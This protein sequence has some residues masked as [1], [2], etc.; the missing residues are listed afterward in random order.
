MA[1]DSQQEPALPIGDDSTRKSE[2]LL[3][4]YFRTDANKKILSSTLDQLV[5]SGVAEKINGYYGR[6]TAK[7]FRSNDD[8]IADVSKQR[9][10]RQLEPAATVLDDLGNVQFYADYSD[11][12]NQAKNFNGNVE[13][14]S[15]FNSQ[16]YYSWNPNVDWDK[17]TNF[18]EYYW[19][20]N[21]PQTVTVFGKNTDEQ[22][23][24]TVTTEDNDDNTVYKFDP[25]GFE[26]NPTLTLYRGQTYK[27]KIDSVGHPFSITTNRKFDDTEF[28]VIYDEDSET[29]NLI[30]PKSGEIQAIKN[31]A[32]PSVNRSVGTYVVS[33]YQ[34]TGKG[35]FATFEVTVRVGGS[36]S[37]AVLEGGEDFVPG[38]VITIFDEDLGEGGAVNVRFEVTKIFNINLDKSN[39]YVEGLKAFDETG[40]PVAPIGLEKG[41]IEFTVPYNAPENLYY[42][43]STD[44]N[45]SGYIKI[46]NI[47]DRTEINVNDI[48][49][50][51]TYT[52]ANGVEFTNGLKV[53]FAGK[54]TPEKYSTGEWYVEGVGTKIELVNSIDLTITGAFTE[55]RLVPFDSDPFDRLP[56]GDD[57][58]Y[59]RDK[60]YHVI[61]R[62]SVDR[63]AWSRYNRWFHIDVIA[64][65]AEYNGQQFVVD[66][67]ARATRPIV[68]F[69]TGLKLFN[70]GTQSKQSIDVIDTIT[71]DAFSIVEGSTG[72]NV[73]EVQLSQGMRIIFLADPDTLVYGKIFEVNFITI[74]NN[75]QISLIE[76]SDTMPLENEN[77]LVKS[78]QK[79]GGK[80]YYFDGTHWNLAQEKLSANQA[81]LFDLFDEDGYSL[82]DT[83]YYP[84]SSFAGNKVFGYV[85][86]TLE[87]ND[88]E[89]GFP[90]S[91]KSIENIGDILFEFPLVN[92]V[93]QYQVD[94]LLQFTTTDKAYLRTYKSLSEYELH[95]G[96]TKAE[97]NSEQAVV[98][99]YVLDQDE[100]ELELDAFDNILNLYKDGDLSISTFVN[101]V[102]T[103]EFRYIE[104]VDKLKIVVA[105]SKANDSVVIKQFSSATANDNGYYDMA[106]NLERNPLNDNPSIFT[107]GE[108]NDHV[109]SIVEEVTSNN[110]YNVNKAAKKYNG[111]FP[112]RS[113]LRDLGNVD[114]FGKRFIKH[115]GPV[116][117]AMYH[118]TDKDAN[119]VKAIR[120]SKI[121]YAKFK[122]EFLQV[123][124]SLGYDGPVK[125]HVDKIL[126][127]INSEKTEGMPFYFSD[128]VPISGAKLTQFEVKPSTQNFF[129]LNRVFNLNELSP[130]AVLVYRNGDQLLHNKD[131]VFTD[132]GF[133]DISA[134]LIVGDIIDVY[135]YDSTDGSFIPS[136]PTKLGLYPAFE[137]QIYRDTTSQVPRNVIQG[138]DGSLILAYGDYRD[139]LLLDL[140]KRIFNNIKQK[141]NKEVFDIHEFVGGTFRDTRFT[142]EQI[143][144]S[145]TTDF[146][147]WYNIAGTPNYTANT[148]YRQA[149]PFTYNFKQMISPNGKSLPGFWRGVYKE[150]FD[151][152]RPHTHPW[153]M[154][155]FT[156]KPKWWEEQY[157]AAPY[158]ASNLVMWEDL[159][160]GLIKEPG[161]AVY[162]DKKYARPGLRNWLPVDDQGKLIDPLTS[163]YA[164][165]YVASDTREPYAF[166]D[167][168]PAESAW[169]QSAEYPFA[170][171]IS[172]VVSQPS[173]VVGTGFDLSR[174]VRNKVGNLVYKETGNAIR[175]TDLRFPNTTQADQRVLTSG[176]VNFV[177]N[178]L[179][180]NVNVT[181]E[182]YINKLTNLSNNLAI[183]IG[184]YTEKEKFNLILDSRTPLNQG[185]VF[186]PKE[187][188]KII[189]N[190]SSPIDFAS[191]SGVI[192]EKA[193]NGFIV[194][195]YDQELSIFKHFEPISTQFDPVINVGGISEEF[196]NWKER[197]QYIKGQNVRFNTKYYRVVESHVSTVDFD[198]TKFKEIA[199]LPQV[200]GR[201]GILRRQFTDRLIETPYGTLLRT[202][203]DVVDFLLGYEEYLKQQGFI[204]DYFNKETSV[205]EDWTY[206]VK[207][208]LFWTTQ[209]WAAGTVLALSP[210][211][212]QIKFRRDFVVVDDIFDKFYNYSLIKA[213]GKRIQRNFSSIARDDENF[214][215]LRVKNTADGIYGVKLPLVQREHVVLLDNETV[216]GDV[217]YDQTAGYR[218]ERIKVTGYRSDNWKG[219]LNAPGFIY[220]EA[221]VV[222]WEPWADYSIGTLVKYKEFYY[223][224][225]QTIAGS[226]VFIANK[227]QRL[228]EKPE[229]RLT[230]NFDYK[231]N[232]FGDFYDLDSDNFDVEQQ[233]HAQH[234]IGYQ[235]RQYLQNIINDD[236]S[237]YKFYQGMIQDKGTTNALTKLFDALSSANKDSLEFYEE[238][239]LR[240]GQYGAVDSYDEVEFLLDESKFRIDPQ[241]IEN[242][243]ELPIDD[244]DLTYKIREFEIFSKPKVYN[245]LSVFPTVQ[246]ENRDIRSSG[247]VN[248]KDVVYR[249]DNLTD[250]LNADVN[251]IGPNDYIWVTGRTEDWDVLQHITTDYKVVSIQGFEASADAIDD[252][253]TPLAT[254]VLTS[255]TDFKV[256]DV[257]GIRNLGPGNDGFYQIDGIRNN[258]LDLVAG[259]RQNITDVDDGDGYISILRSVR[260]QNIQTANS[261]IEKNLHNNQLLWI[262][263]QTSADWNVIEKKESFVTYKEY[264]NDYNIWESSGVEQTDIVDSYASSIAVSEEN[265]VIA[266]ANPTSENGKVHIYSRPNYITEFILQDILKPDLGES[267][268]L[269]EQMFGESIDISPDGRLLV[270]G[271]PHSSD[272]ADFYNNTTYSTLSQYSANQIVKYEENYWRA[273]RT[274][275]PETSSVQFSTFDAY[276]FI[277][278]S[279]DNEGLLT[280][281]REEDDPNLTLTDIGDIT[282]ILQG[283]P[284]F[285]NTET[286]HLLIRAPY[287]QYRATKPNDK[288][289]LKWNEYTNLNRGATLGNSIQLFTN[290]INTAN[291]G[292]NYTIPD[293]DF[294]T[295]EHLIVA[296]VDYVL[297]FTQFQNPP[298]DGDVVETDTGAATVYKQTI[299]QDKMVLYLTG[300]NGEILSSDTLRSNRTGEEIGQFTQPNYTKQV[301]LGG[302]WYINS[303]TY[304]TSNEFTE[305][306]NF[307]IPGFGLV[308]QDVLV[309]DEDTDSYPNRP[310]SPT[311]DSIPNYYYNILDDV[312]TVG[313]TAQA[314]FLATLSHIGDAYTSPA[315]AKELST[316]M[317][318]LPKSIEDDVVVG[319]N[320]RVYVDSQSPSYDYDLIGI[321]Q[322]LEEINTQQHEVLDLWD[323][324]IDF[325]QEETQAGS[326]TDQ[327]GDTQDFFEPLVGS[328]IRD[329]F[330]RETAEVAY[331]IKRSVNQA[332]V[333][334]K[335]VS[336]TF[337]QGNKLIVD[338]IEL[339]PQ[340][341]P[342]TNRRVMGPIARTSLASAVTGKL[343]ILA[344]P[345][346]DSNPQ[347][348]NYLFPAH[349][350]SYGG[351]DEFFDLNVFCYTNQEYWIYKEKLDEEGADLPPSI[352]STVNADWQLVYNM[353][354]GVGA[355]TNG[356]T[357]QGTYSIYRYINSSWQFVNTYTLP[358]TN[359][360]SKAGQKVKI[361]QDGLLYTIF[362]GSKEKVYIIKHGEDSNGNRYEY[363]LDID[364]KYR[365]AYNPNVFYAIN[366]IVTYTYNI[367]IVQY[368]SLFQAKTFTNTVPTNT[369]KW[370]KLENRISYLPY[371][372]N[373]HA[374]Y[375]DSD[376]SDLI[377]DAD[378]LYNPL[379]PSDQILDFSQDIAVS[380][381]GDVLAISIK[382]TETEATYSSSTINPETGLPIYTSTMVVDTDN[383]V[384]IYR[385]QDSRYVFHQQIL[386]PR[387]QT[388]WG[389]SIDLSKDGNL[390][391][392]GE[393]GND[394]DSF[395]NGKVYVYAVDNATHFVE[396]QRIDGPSA[397]K[398]EKFGSKVSITHDYLGVS[399]FNGDVTL[400][401][402][403]DRYLNSL[404][405]SYELDTTS[406][407]REETTFDDGFTTFVT[408]KV[409]SGSVTLYQNF[410]NHFIKA[411]ELEYKE[412]LSVLANSRFGETLVVNENNIY[413]GIPNNP[414][415][416]ETEEYR[417]G[418][419]LDYSMVKGTK[420]WEVIRTRN[421]VVDTDKIK[422]AFLY[423]TTRNELITYL[424]FIDPVQGKIAGPADKELSFKS[425]IDLAR[426]NVTLYPSYFSETSNWENEHVG[427][428]WWDLSAVRFKDAYQEDPI[429][430]ANSW[431]N[432]IP[433]YSVDVYEWVESDV[434]PSEWDTQSENGTGRNNGISGTSKY[435]DEAYSQ[436]LV[437]DPISSSF[438]TK[439]YFWVKD[440]DIIP[441]VGDR[442]MSALNVS[443]MIA[444]PRGQGYQF[445]ALLSDNRFVLY[446]CDNLIKG[447]TVA[448]NIGYY[449]RDGAADQNIHAEYQILSEGLETSVP[450]LDI[451]RK[452]VDSLVGYDTKG[453]PVPDR[454]IP[455][456]QRYGNLNYPRQSW[457]V[458]RDEA[459]KQLV[460]RANIALQ[461]N[462][463]VDEFSFANLNKKEAQPL[464][465]QRL[466]DIKVD[467][468]DDLNFVGTI[469][470][471]SAQINVVQNNG[472]IT[473]T[474]IVKSGRGYVDP[475][476]DPLTSAKRFG[477]S[478]TVIGNGEGLELDFTINN[479]GQITSVDIINGGTNYD[480]STI[481]VVRPLSVLVESDSSVNGLWSIYHY[482]NE[483]WQ[484]VRVQS[485]NTE[486]Y[487]EYIDWYAT[488]YNQFT[489]IDYIVDYSYELSAL[490]TNIG[491]IVKI[492]SIGSGGWLLLRKVSDTGARDY[493]ID[494]ETIGRENG[495]IRI[496]PKLYDRG[497]SLVGFD[498]FPYDG[499]FYDSEPVQETRNILAALKEDIFV[500]N[501]ALKYN[502]LFFASIR[503][504]L[505]EQFNVDWVFKTSF[506]KAKHNVG[507]LEEK[508]TYQ[509]DNLE[510]YNDYINEVKPYKTNVREYLSS[511]E[512]IE[513]TQTLVTDFDVPAIYNPDTGKIQPAGIIVQNDELTRVDE[514][515]SEY[516][517][518]NWFDNVGFKVVG[519]HLYDQ[520]SGYTYPPTI[521]FVGGGGSG[522]EAKAYLGAGKIKSIEVTNPGKG[523]KSAP[524]VIVDGSISDNG[525][526]AIASAEIG[527][528]VTRSMK[529]GVKFDRLTGDYFIENLPQ[530]ETFTGTGTRTIYTLSWPM[531]MQ[532]NKVTV[533]VNDVKLLRNDYTYQN[534]PNTTYTYKRYFGEIKF[535]IP[536]EN[537]S[538]IRVEYHKDPAM[539]AAQDRINKFYAPTAGMPGI[540]LGQLME[541]VDYGGVQVKSFDFGGPAGWDT[542][543]WFSS[544]WDTYDNTFEDQ[545][546]VADG[547]TTVIEL[548]NPLETGVEYNVYR[549]G[550]RIDDPDYPDNPKNPNAIMTSIIGDGEQLL[551]DLTEFEITGLPGDRFIV[552]KSSS[553]GSFLPDPDSYDTILTGGDLNYGNAAGTKAE[554]IIVD[555]DL[556]VTSITSGGPEELVPGQVLDAVAITVFERVGAGSGDIIHQTMISDGTTTVYPMGILPGSDSSVIIK[557][558]GLLYRTT[559]YRLDYQAQTIIL[560]SPIAAGKRISILTVASSGEDILD[561]NTILTNGTDVIYK[562]NTMWRD[563]LQFFA[564]V[565]GRIAKGVELVIRESTD[566]FVEFEFNPDAP[567]EGT[568]LDYEIYS[569]KDEIN[570][571]RVTRD[572]IFADDTDTYTL[573]ESPGDKTPAEFFTLVSVDNRIYK[574]GYQSIFII[575]NITQTE[576]TLE[577][578]QVP[579]TSMTSDI[580]QVYL[581]NRRLLENE[582][583]TINSGNSSINIVANLTSLDDRLEV[584]VSNGEYR[585]FDDQLQFNK[586]IVL[587]SIIEVLQ[588]T[589]HSIPGLERMTYDVTRQQLTENDI[590]FV[591]YNNITAGKIVLNTPANSVNHVW[592]AKDKRLLTPSV[593]YVLDDDNQVIY[594][595]E[596][597]GTGGS[598]DVIQFGAQLSTPV[599][600]FKQFK[601]ILNRTQY[602]RF[603]NNEGITLIKPFLYND[604]RLE[605]TDASTLP[606]PSKK[607]NKP[608]I[609]FIGGERIEYFAKTGNSLRQLRRGTLGTGTKDV[610]EVGTPIVS[611]SSDKTI[612][613]KD[614]IITTNYTSVDNQKNFELDWVPTRGVDEFEV[615]AAGRRLRKNSIESFDATLGLD[616]PEGNVTLPAEF[617]VVNGSTLQLAQPLQEGQKLVVIRKLGKIWS[618]TGTPLKD[619]DNDIARFLRD[620]NS[621]LPK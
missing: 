454:D 92:D 174:T 352:P 481:I 143:N 497:D 585:I 94:N 307:G 361:A 530:T 412:D 132:E 79:N 204:F 209:N 500:D 265:T 590:E 533:F 472:V 237:Q 27:F 602:K 362:V 519:I 127:K 416:D 429:T 90:V 295:G 109:A 462:I 414:N 325:T 369:N 234:L 447:K 521:T 328:T 351:K 281:N 293:S 260:S 354:V 387:N 508:I 104:T 165:N 300:T 30:T 38:E 275:E 483:N 72:Y 349:P 504:V 356:K 326:D 493:T 40:K 371:I 520:G 114:I 594:L 103:E 230:P 276:P 41:E 284:Y 8:Y 332:R 534:V 448:L 190:T 320:I 613:Y 188:Y 599:I 238:W 280:A 384:L 137:P 130:R 278:I 33:N 368:T 26:S 125:T 616:S 256:R 449:L 297:Y 543:E 383:K 450:K 597:V 477:P 4:K 5:Q 577:T 170:L 236:V 366:D 583:Y 218:Q 470:I 546:F 178:Y 158:T 426:Y 117:L 210:G 348:G 407:T 139:Q 575:D 419:F 333:Y 154:L 301:A 405:E 469:K 31:K 378:P 527:D 620:S 82:S 611:G 124:E 20:P 395:N 591:R 140:E 442:S 345:A 13:N 379:I 244:T 111:I 471:E 552:R 488:G 1:N 128:M 346:T 556:F 562:T 183:K 113:N 373:D 560:N 370:I 219:G 473:K 621:R 455:Y 51:Q 433:N 229:P 607:Q 59:A 179:T 84:D 608:G 503:Y 55:N 359:S 48:I 406:E 121:E 398:S 291:V 175:V 253:D 595:Q 134:E 43:S 610:Y 498:Q 207:E 24:F 505:S 554:D 453:R 318:R 255:T 421:P 208:F 206:S 44:I 262:D 112:G 524:T 242:V 216:F 392:V 396:K 49:G 161:K 334:V 403:F 539:L 10:I 35:K 518:K 400:D 39:K 110:I 181:Y 292:V 388:D 17:L 189:L 402:R 522:A 517:D 298:A 512:K 308:Y 437:Y 303:P 78:G 336:G 617:A 93:V 548:K 565:N 425:H 141:Y 202:I 428:L 545:L 198:G 566:G 120:F 514:R 372:P 80:I 397:N 66:Q 212:Q 311:G 365:G 11:F 264:N 551:I 214:F 476:F 23:T 401:T 71:T 306:K 180:A 144:K 570:Y 196:I 131:Y 568:R 220:D 85:V 364:K 468:V 227:W 422:H 357:N 532:L 338:T 604:L 176:L 42:S 263:G 451:E 159:E 75:R 192:L 324:Y 101:G 146:I 588:F 380:R 173:K 553:D 314:G 506:I 507:E 460:E 456:K 563:D 122:R 197:K 99:Q 239:A 536:P 305:L 337:S 98:T 107:L 162:V 574:P 123:A 246:N 70:Y 118:I 355:P 317:V 56:F 579:T 168:S 45:T 245:H 247:Y 187:N 289:V 34:T 147:Q 322:V 270:V 581:N 593:D 529:V 330:T 573:T 515:F 376:S 511:Y 601:D 37:I 156:I 394:Q 374:I 87:D 272:V 223:V 167:H 492:A 76:T 16:E 410:D 254:V 494:W 310:L 353:P 443:R 221:R 164:S 283:T 513:N 592:V 350:E 169:R 598:V 393:P 251:R 58:A 274:V 589:N 64:K 133:I 172:W 528:S 475:T 115:S 614:E 385:L 129:A 547:S 222:D 14:Q 294:I 46:F 54:V 279:A 576:F 423:D 2:N 200:G 96:W 171:I 258:R 584:F 408:K 160:L 163:G 86:G 495:T 213:D 185:N 321:T 409:D 327:D 526:P 343:A 205:V 331:Y 464:P 341:N 363:A 100:E 404:P 582:E 184:G 312:Y 235:K 319:E 413:V 136:T 431:N 126:Q 249:I 564:R 77:V 580:V 603:D 487:W 273:V 465:T 444:D 510:S 347:P 108:I 600:A 377:D 439:Y 269:E 63:N 250:I 232:Q 28:R 193:A 73:D 418:S 313:L 89:L 375:T 199:D 386:A 81:P 65:S 459:L 572:R 135:E 195:G 97:F 540:D 335:N 482:V 241:P 95:T 225:T 411:E 83:T 153:E 145:L 496:L 47:I 88:P 438:S 191:F 463:I 561:I 606:V 152:D 102:I 203:Q 479:L 36:V 440:K 489:R 342:Q 467:T 474:R 389:S 32:G 91:Y 267:P 430:Q 21:G 501:L 316:W 257:I 612:P 523:Y 148:F 302:W 485:F 457:F 531:D 224:A 288:I 596:T 399:S 538:V 436:K 484:R 427:K 252:T 287:D 290:G 441:P 228:N 52:S 382:T 18:R 62:A 259:P 323:G 461:Q 381:K 304:I 516:P 116:N 424:D 537:N 142:R 296:K 509:N 286:S 15:L 226:E 177:Y 541:G 12:I 261:I 6:K 271:S 119:I 155:G 299:D 571:S 211:A 7:A 367:G 390:L 282:L 415:D 569:N 587:G 452:W 201:D 243:T 446:N 360:E 609:I 542:D 391:V 480:D 559:N 557:V 19:L 340:G 25:P 558:D 22:S 445:V 339:D 491:N 458:N 231:V 50:K 233:K 435:G 182:S 3:P 586:E 535:T 151:T 240:L 549:N 57:R 285:P 486:N 106:A 166:G 29:Y 329:Q 266:V 217:I 555:G 138:H 60:D 277:E 309:Y 157:G 499:R 358:E 466:Y 490:D 74:D 61:N 9:Q 605:V 478:Y 68:E 67:T 434:L 248:D 618:E 149:L 215:G 615:F 567:P 432:L 194:R 420:S 619:A 550:I 502:E 417:P 344:S 268:M 105:G 69:N 186:V 544:T 315:S 578:S 53:K 150:A 525:R